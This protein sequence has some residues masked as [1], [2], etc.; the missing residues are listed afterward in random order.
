VHELR[1]VV[2]VGN[3]IKP[4]RH[5]GISTFIA[6]LTHCGQTFNDLELAFL[7]RPFRSRQA[8]GGDLGQIL[9]LAIQKDRLGFQSS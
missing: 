1:S 4:F 7:L 9:H 3:S 8:A 2:I 5:P 6:D